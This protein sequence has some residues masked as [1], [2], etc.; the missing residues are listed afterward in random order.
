MFFSGDAA[1]VIVRAASVEEA[2]EMLREKGYPSAE[3]ML[4][5]SVSNPDMVLIEA[6]S[7]NSGAWIHV[8]GL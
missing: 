1:I 8:E 7:S 2:H 6:N 3:G 5:I 4:P